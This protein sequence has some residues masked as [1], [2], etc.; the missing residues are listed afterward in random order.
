MLDST[1]INQSRPPLRWLANL[2][3]EISTSAIMRVSWAEE[4]GKD[5]GFRYKL[6]GFLYDNL[7]PFYH[8]YGTYYKLDIDM[9]GP[10]WNDYDENGVPYWDKTG[11]VDPDYYPW[12]FEDSNGD[13]FRVI[14]N[15]RK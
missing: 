11:V 6:D 10:E 8:K 13:A 5:K 3:G 1:K 12:N 2:A 4:D 14:K 9:S 7:F 15:V